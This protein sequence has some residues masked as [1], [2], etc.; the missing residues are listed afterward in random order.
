VRISERG[1]AETRMQRQ[2]EEK[3]KNNRQT[4]RAEAS[5]PWRRRVGATTPRAR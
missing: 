5:D 4:S 2:R 3:T 1:V